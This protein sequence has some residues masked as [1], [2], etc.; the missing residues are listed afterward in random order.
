MYFLVAKGYLEINYH[1][2]IVDLVWFETLQN[3]WSSSRFSSQAHSG[4]K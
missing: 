3:I 1:R 4:G 2:P